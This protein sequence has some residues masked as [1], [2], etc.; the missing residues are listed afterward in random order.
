VRMNH[1][2]YFKGS[3]ALAR[4]TDKALA[5]NGFIKLPGQ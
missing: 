3:V 5:P 4:F 2:N 1:V